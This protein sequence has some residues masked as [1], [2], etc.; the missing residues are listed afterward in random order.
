L[1]LEE[2]LKMS[3]RKILLEQV[4]DPRRSQ[5]LRVTLDQMFCIII[6]S[7][8]CGYFGGRPVAKFG[9]LHEATLTK[10]LGLKHPVP[11]HVVFS[12]LMNRV[13]E[14]QL[15]KAFNEWTKNY[16]PLKKG[17]LLS[18][19]GKALGSTVKNAH[20]KKQTFTGIVSLFC[21]KSGLVH[22]IQQYENAKISEQ[23]I[24]R[25]LVNKLKTKGLVLF[26]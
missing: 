18:G 15:I 8:L 20:N 22:S 17:D 5:G 16:V 1:T 19:D 6:I 12:D 26:F 23:N 7:N 13:D 11:S 10:L 21:Q 9:Q 2:K 25:L 24:V 4:D 14:Q 3:L